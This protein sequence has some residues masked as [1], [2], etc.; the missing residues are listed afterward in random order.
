MGTGHSPALAPLQ[1]LV[2]ISSGVLWPRLSS[3]SGL[4]PL[5]YTS[6]RRV[7][8]RSVW[9]TDTNRA[10]R[11][12]VTQDRPCAKV[13]GLVG[14]G[15]GGPRRSHTPFSCS[16]DASWRKVLLAST[17]PL[18][19]RGCWTCEQVTPLRKREGAVCEGAHTP[20]T[21]PDSGAPHPGVPSTQY[22]LHDIHKGGCEDV[23][24]SMASDL[25]AG[26]QG[27]CL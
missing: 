5:P 16:R 10:Q 11:G 24:P 8:P 20:H 12:W 19:L 17:G 4:R 26:K 9:F 22:T 6:L 3:C 23:Q 14:L 21:N 2:P 13:H 18:V 25:E 1:S 15:G 7:L 27:T